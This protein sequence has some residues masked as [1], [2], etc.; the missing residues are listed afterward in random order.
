[1]LRQTRSAD[2]IVRGLT[3]TN[4]L[5]VPSRSPNLSTHPPAGVR[6]KRVGELGGRE[7][8]RARP[9]NDG[10]QEKRRQEVLAQDE[11]RQVSQGDSNETGRNRT[12]QTRIDPT[13][14]EPNRPEPTRPGPTG[15]N[16]VEPRTG[17]GEFSR[18]FCVYCC[19]F[20][21]TFAWSCLLVGALSVGARLRWALFSGF[22]AGMRLHPNPLVWFVR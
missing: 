14:P 12:D 5:P 1:M 20:L 16:R 18:R 3:L 10:F 19:H 2:P 22:G 13:R 21:A 8:A 11:G 4:P 17:Q 15:P 9:A 6:H 7:G